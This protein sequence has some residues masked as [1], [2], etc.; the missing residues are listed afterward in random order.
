VWSARSDNRLLALL[1]AGLIIAA[2]AA[3]AVWGASPKSYLLDHEALGRSGL[4]LDGAYAATFLL[5]VAGWS[6][7]TVA[8][9]LPTSLPLVM[10]FRT[11]TRQRA[12]RWLLTGLV[13][14]G[15]LA[16][17][18]AFGAL[19]HF[20]D[21]WL[22]RIVESNARLHANAWVLGALPLL[23]A[24]AYQFTPLKYICLDKCRSPYSFIVEHWRGGNAKLQSLRLGLHHGLFCVGCCWSLMLLMFA[25]SLGNLAW[26]LALAL[27]MG[28]EKN[29]PLGRRLSVPLGVVLL[30]AGVTVVALN[31]GIA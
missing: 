18:T 20:G 28:I 4:S 24:G 23:V 29:L 7:M 26:M 25:V 5:F 15:Y 31:T 19:A 21:F 30:S 27:V 6:L 1:L 9:M 12:N 22:H 17:W 16:V 3:L 11:V 10:L 13:L 14:A 2:W 8:M